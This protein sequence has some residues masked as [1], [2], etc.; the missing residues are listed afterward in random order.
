MQDILYNVL[1]NPMVLSFIQPIWLLFQS[2]YLINEVA[3]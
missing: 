2:D 3:D 1:K